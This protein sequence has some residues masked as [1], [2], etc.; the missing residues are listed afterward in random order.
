MGF[1]PNDSD[2]LD[3]VVSES[4]DLADAIEEM[5]FERR[6]N[7]KLSASLT[8]NVQVLKGL[9]HQAADMQFTDITCQGGLKGQV[10][11][12][13]NFVDYELM[14]FGILE[15]LTR[16]T[17]S[18]SNTGMEYL[19]VVAKTVTPIGGYHKVEG[20]REVLDSVWYGA[21]VVMLEGTAGALAIDVG[22]INKRGIARPVTEQVVIGPHDGF[23]EDG[24]T[25]LSL[26][27]QRLRTPR[28]WIGRVT[29]GRET[30]TAVYVLSLYGVT[31]DRLVGEITTRLKAIQIDGVL[32]SNY[33]VEIMRADKWTI[34][35]TVMRTDR[36]DR[37]AAALLEGRAA[38]V[39]DGTP[40]AIIVP[41]TL[42][43][44]M[45]AAADYYQNWLVASLLRVVRYIAF[46]A[47]LLIPALYVALTTY[48]Q[49]AIPTPLLITMAAARANVPL[50]SV[51]EVLILMVMFDI[52]REAGARVPS[53]V[54]SALTIGG[55]L[56]VGDAAV[57][58]GIVSSPIIIVV[59]GIVI[60]IYAIPSYDLGLA[61]RYATYPFI[62][63]AAIL[64]LYGILFV[65]IALG[66]HLASLESFGVPFLSPGA[67]SRPSEYKDFVVRAPWFRQKMR[68]ASTAY[69]DPVRQGQGNQT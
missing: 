2:V 1:D 44:L 21:A 16:M 61:V 68:P 59:A 56:V 63:A 54:G 69:S 57:K 24:M 36:P 37:V 27:R 46:F 12:D 33:L 35:P 51:G 32:E 26:V 39:V 52:I 15:P 65:S 25:N 55:T 9:I 42:P 45:T 50:P 30:K 20:I 66:L 8:E 7:S 49:E 64:G 34:F 6:L 58:A 53:G 11:Y 29:V 43:M 31:D 60:A 3:A 5:L 41:A 14:A 38:L 62:L 18:S 23:I 28:F 48:H 40:M 47:S 4:G 17:F 19:D 13:P 10:I 67:P 22:K